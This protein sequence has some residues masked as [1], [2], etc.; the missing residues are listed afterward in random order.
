MNFLSRV[1]W[2][3]G[4][5][6]G[7]H[8]FQA[9]NRYFEDSLHFAVSN[10][11]YQPY[12]L[13]GCEFDHDA[14]RNGTLALLTARGIFDDGMPFLM[15]ECDALPEPR[16]IGGL[17]PVTQERMGVAL[18]IPKRK[19]Q[20]INCILNPGAGQA[21]FFAQSRELPDETTGIDER[22]VRLGRK[23][24]R[25][26]LDT[27]PADG[28][29]TLA[30]ARIMRDGRGHLAFDPEFIPPCLEISASERLMLLLKRLIEILEEKS[31]TL[32]GSRDPHPAGDIS[33]RDLANFWLL[34][35][36]NSAL[37]PLRH[38][39]ITKRSHPEELFVE[40]S[41]LAGALCTFGLDSHP[42]TLPLYDHER[43]TECFDALDR[44]IRA[45]LELVLPTNCLNIPLRKVAN[46]F[47][48]GEVN[49]TRC[50]GRARWVLGIRSQI[51][52]AEIIT[53]T[54]Q[55][56]KVCSAKWINELVRR[57]VAGL[58]L[59]HLPRP[60]SAIQA[61]LEMQYFAINRAGPFWNNV[62]DTKG[63]GIYVP[64]DFPEPEV[65]LL[66]VLEP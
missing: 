6:L 52:E 11:W 43:L 2:S 57:A 61:K 58:D 17:L 3:E 27:E 34:H 45:H 4:M 48:E 19:P 13:L 51:P 24:T 22:P 7:P 39:S 23:N 26:L 35:A 36:V 66:V 50:F 5:F 29:T 44:H 63:V 49:D 56:V 40:F 55:L 41:R 47:Y 16:P 14:L 12:G 28:M 10:L 15:P 54:P 42:R 8:H 38:L 60:P 59:T 18:A 65:E 32:R 33:A 64:G 31:T 53:K 37:S 30:L 20:G 9:Q 25:L 1:V 62:V 21:R 46:Y